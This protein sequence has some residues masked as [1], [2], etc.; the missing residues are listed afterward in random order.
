M[1]TAN[2]GRSTMLVT[3]SIASLAG[4]VVLL[5]LFPASVL[6]SDPPQ[7]LSTFNYRVPCGF[8]DTGP[9]RLSEWSLAAGGAS[10]AA[11]GLALRRSRCGR[12]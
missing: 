4:F 12:G 9:F 7:C 1:T 8:I 5:C 6:T 3:V 10:A 11:V 2:R